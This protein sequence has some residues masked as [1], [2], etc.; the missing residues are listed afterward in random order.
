MRTL[1][2][3]TIFLA[4]VAVFHHSASA[5][6]PP[7]FTPSTNASLPAKYNALPISPAG[8]HVPLND[9]TSPPI[10][11]PPTMSSLIIM[12]DLD[13]PFG[14]LNRSF[15]PFLHWIATP[16]NSSIVPYLPPAPPPGSP[17]HRFVLLCYKLPIN[18][19]FSMPTGWED[20]GVTMGGMN[21]SRFDVER[22]VE[23]AELGRLSAANWF[24]VVR[25]A[26]N[27][28]VPAEFTSGES[29]GAAGLFD[30]WLVAIVVGSIVMLLAE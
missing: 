2:L 18:E 4:A 8:I 11:T 17:E 25:E 5:Q 14:A 21:R 30:V 26:E 20:Y 16:S 12:I 7:G 28:T 9:T 29:S 24:T 19:S 27:G 13:T 3:S 22:F 1:S 23:A 10:L 6:S 15:A